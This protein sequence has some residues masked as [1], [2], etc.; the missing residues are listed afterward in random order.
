MITVKNLSDYDLIK[1]KNDTIDKGYPMVKLSIEKGLYDKS[2]DAK[3]VVDKWIE[4]ANEFLKKNAPKEDSKPAKEPKK[5]PKSDTKKETKKEETDEGKA[6]KTGSKKR[7]STKKD[8]QADKS[9]AP[10]A[11]KESKPKVGEKPAWL[12]TL[13]SFVNSYA[14]Q[15]KDT[16]RVRDFVRKIQGSFNAKL[17]QKTPNI[18]LIR[19]IQD[20]LITYANSDKKKVDIPAYADLV[21]KCKAAIK[22]KE[23]TVSRSVAKPEIKSTSLS[24]IKK[25]RKTKKTRK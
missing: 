1:G 12:S 10:K 14:G 6:K 13:Q 4:K 3:R 22:A 9:E 11:K 15:S 21:A 18:D 23:F 7:T 5:K 19:D 16:W 17:G 2:A 20:K 8:T 25:K 24:G